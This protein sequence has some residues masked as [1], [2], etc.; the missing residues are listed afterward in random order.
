MTD[1]RN[2]MG[3]A[4]GKGKILVIGLV[5]A[6]IGAAGVAS[7]MNAAKISNGIR[8]AFSSPAEYYQYVEQKN[9]DTLL[10]Y[11]E[12]IYTSARDNLTAWKEGQK[13]IYTMELGDTL[14][15]LM[16]N[17]GM[18]KMSL[19]T[20]GRQNDTVTTGKMQLQLNDKDALSCNVYL[21]AASG[22]SYIQMP[23]LTK[24]YLDMTS[25]MQEANEELDANKSFATLMNPDEYLP[26]AAD[27]TGLMTDYS[28][29]VIDHVAKKHQD[30][31]KKTDH[32]VVSAGDISQKSTRLDVN[33]DDECGYEIGKDVLETMK[34]DDLIKKML[35]K[36]DAS[37]Y[38]DFQDSVEDTLAELEDSKPETGEGQMQMQVY[39]DAKANIIG[40]S[41]RLKADGENFT[42]QQMCPRDGSDYAYDLSV[43]VD[44]VTYLEIN[45][46]GSVENGMLSG[47]FSLSLDDSLNEDTSGAILSMK[48]LLQ[49][50]VKKLDLNTLLQKGMIKGELTFSTDQVPKLSGYTLHIKMDGTKDKRKEELSVMVGSDRFAMLTIQEEKGEDPGV[51]KPDDSA[52]KY[53]FDDELQLSLYTSEIDLASFLTELRTN[54]SVDLMPFY[55][56]FI[57]GASY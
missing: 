21:D 1:N 8:K 15:A 26:E 23:E 17:N 5:I 16:G 9:R 47:D 54:T 33:C 38:Q 53:D 19:T 31:V 20:L 4:A 28:D 37:V 13:V 32:A 18:E 24:S 3:K 46:S 42:I 51:A 39:V 7:A 57:T 36:V 34:D 35:E 25:T 56:Q 27:I 12:K 41:I 49:V 48:D 40:R 43:T 44:D 6:V 52:V 14:K 45:G 30:T 11:N 29:I 10:E 2:E 22:E 50:S 55:E